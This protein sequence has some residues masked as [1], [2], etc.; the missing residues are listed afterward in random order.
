MDEAR[1]RYPSP[2]TADVERL[3]TY[4]L[5]SIEKDIPRT[6]PKHEAFC[7]ENSD[8]QKALRNVLQRYAALDRAVNY[9][10]GMSF[11]AGVFV[12]LMPAEES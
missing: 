9:C 11:T 10:Q 1:L 3:D 8:G 5:S 7:D 12:T 4:V 6:F 2:S